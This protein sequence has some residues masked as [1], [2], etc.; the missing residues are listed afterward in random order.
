M[1]L[2]NNK[3]NYLNSTTE[4]SWLRGCFFN[5]MFCTKTI[6]FNTHGS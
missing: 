6:H 1:H 4:M 2:V 3:L 5:H